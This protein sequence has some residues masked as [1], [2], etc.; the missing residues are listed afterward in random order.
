M[1]PGTGGTQR[2]TRLVGKTKAIELMTTGTNMNME[3]AHGLGIVNRLFDAETV[4]AFTEQVMEFA[5][6][7]APPGRASMAVGLIKR[8]C[9]SGAEMGLEQGL[10]LERELQQRLFLSDDAREGI[11]AFNEKRPAAFEGK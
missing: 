4:D 10:A 2:L 9:Q 1:L 7:F 6:S 3:A 5:R 8:A 11:T